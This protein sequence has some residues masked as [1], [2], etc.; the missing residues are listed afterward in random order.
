MA[1]EWLRTCGLFGQ[2]F[3]SSP[4]VSWNK[5]KNKREKGCISLKKQ[6]YHQHNSVQDFMNMP[7]FSMFFVCKKSR[8]EQ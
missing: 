6:Q 1:L 2:K 8:Q 7:F 4:K 3:D 5:T